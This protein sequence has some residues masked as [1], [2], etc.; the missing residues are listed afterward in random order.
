MSLARRVGITMFVAVALAATFAVAGT[1]NSAPNLYRTVDGVWGPLPAGRT[2]GATSAVYPARDGSGDV[3]VGE[4]CG[5][6]SCADKPDVDP[7]LR[8]TADGELVTSFG[9]GMIL[10]PHGMFVD[11][12]NNVAV[13]EQAFGKVR[14]EKAGRPGNDAYRA[15]QLTTATAWNRLLQ[16]CLA[17]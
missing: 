8:F 2:W 15:F 9:A 10:W 14:T 3:W 11:A 7:I 4:R 13:V 5:A 12:D 6:N 17:D 16:G 1:Q